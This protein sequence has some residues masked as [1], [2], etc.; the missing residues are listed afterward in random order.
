MAETKKKTAI[1]LFNL[2]GPDSLQ[3][4]R[5]FLFNLF[6]DKAILRLPNPFRI[7]LAWIIST[8]RAP[9]ARLIYEDMGGHS[10]LADNTWKQAAELERRLNKSGKDHNQV[11]ICMRYWDPGAAEVVAAVKEYAPD[12]IILIPLYPQFSTT[13]TASSFVDWDRAA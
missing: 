12:E 13:T 3:A 5:P 4:V 11:F 6:S 10:P 9:K 7:V 2:G 8:L 1:V